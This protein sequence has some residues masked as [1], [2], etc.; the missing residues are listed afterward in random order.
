[1]Q[2]GAG[3]AACQEFL[4]EHALPCG[5]FL[6][7]DTNATATAGGGGGA[8]GDGEGV[9]DEGVNDGGV[10]GES[11]DLAKDVEVIIGLVAHNPC[12]TVRDC[13]HPVPWKGF[14]P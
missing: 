5:M 9:D 1:M 6:T 7:A 11:H 13:W 2:P 8:C 4:R 3:V 10:T 14:A 12:F